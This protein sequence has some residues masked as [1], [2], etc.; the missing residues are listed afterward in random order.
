MASVK[1]TLTQI[2]DSSFPGVGA[3]EFADATGKTIVVH[4]K[5]P[6]A[7]V[8]KAEIGVEAD[9]RCT[10]VTAMQTNILIDIS[11]PD[12]MEDDQGQIHFWVNAD[13]VNE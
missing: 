7:G 11:R 9:L 8:N 6:V 12:A 4:E 13:L 3:F 5:L 10:T 1:V 2:V